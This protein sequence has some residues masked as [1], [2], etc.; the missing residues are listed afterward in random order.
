MASLPKSRISQTR[1]ELQRTRN[2]IEGLK[3][4][5]DSEAASARNNFRSAISRLDAQQQ[6]LELA[7]K[8]YGQIKKNRRDGRQEIRRP[9]SSVAQNER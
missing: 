9:R 5:I 6:N 2:E 4:T 1:I 7:E 8:V 3:R